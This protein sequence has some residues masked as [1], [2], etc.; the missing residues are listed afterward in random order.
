M[1]DPTP[2]DVQFR[3]ID[4]NDAAIFDSTDERETRRILARGIRA[5]SGTVALERGEWTGNRWDW[6]TEGEWQC[7]G[8]GG[9]V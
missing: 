6:R 9:C 3:I 7:L 8:L 5:W 2:D 1:T 4:D